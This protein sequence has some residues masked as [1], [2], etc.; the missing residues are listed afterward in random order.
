VGSPARL[1]VELFYVPLSVD[2]AGTGGAQNDPL[3][4]VR[5]TAA[6]RVR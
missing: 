2:R 5:F 1:G 3:F 6:Y 4:N